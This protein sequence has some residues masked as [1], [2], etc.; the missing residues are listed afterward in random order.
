[1]LDK[2]QPL[3]FGKRLFLWRTIKSFS[4]LKKTL[5]KSLYK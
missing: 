4:K 3:A 2:K 1:M 5:D